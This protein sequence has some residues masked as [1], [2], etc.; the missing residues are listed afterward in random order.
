MIFSEVKSPC[1]T[2][3]LKDYKVLK[4]IFFTIASY[5]IFNSFYMYL[6]VKPTYTSVAKRNIAPEDFPEF[7]LCPEHPIDLDAVK[8]LGY[9]GMWDYFA[10]KIEKDWRHVGW[11]G[12]KSEDINKVSRHIARLK[13]SE[14][15]P[16]D[17]ITPYTSS[18]MHINNKTKKI[19]EIIHF[20]LTVAVYPNHICCKVYPPQLSKLYPLRR[21]RFTFN[22]SFSGFSVYM[23][24]KLTSSFNTHKANMMGDKIVSRKKGEFISYKVQILEDEKLEDDPAYPCIDYKIVGQYAKCVEK[25]IVEQSLKILNC[26][27]PWMTKNEDLW[28]KEITPLGSIRG[29]SWENGTFLNYR[30]ND[31]FLNYHAL[32][33][34]MTVIGPQLKNCLIPCK[35]KK[36][37]VTEV[38]VAKQDTWTHFEGIAIWFEEEVKIT[39]SS[40]NF[41]AE[42][43]YSRIGGI[44]GTSRSFVWLIVLLMSAGGLLLTRYKVNVSSVINWCSLSTI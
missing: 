31:T 34:E 3:L 26:T 19:A 43:M 23:A 4:L 32:L 17:K 14:D 29:S 25:E 12:N 24:D 33:E 8:S 20:N 5:L 30:E 7:I 38:D 6:I 2:L 18:S 41:N 44:I 9:G 22:S 37:H 42:K 36:F 15:C 39:K 21:I 1:Y 35:T 13:S 11:G 10:G 16:I 40:F 28:C 27:P